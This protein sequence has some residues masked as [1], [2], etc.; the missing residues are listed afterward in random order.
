MTSGGGETSREREEY[1]AADERRIAKLRQKAQDE[2][3]S[4]RLT[5]ERLVEL[6]ADLGYETIVSGDDDSAYGRID[7]LENEILQGFRSL[8]AAGEEMLGMF[9]RTF[10]Y[11]VPS[12]VVPRY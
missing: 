3:W 11:N 1:L 12:G 8:R 6:L 7:T 10:H 5:E 9:I 4:D 2:A